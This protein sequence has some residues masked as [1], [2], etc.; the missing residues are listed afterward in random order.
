[1]HRNY[2]PPAAVFCVLGC[3]AELSAKKYRQVLAVL[4]YRR[5]FAAPFEKGLVLSEF[6]F[7]SPPLSCLATTIQKSP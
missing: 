1:M 2:F 4:E 3:Y 7:E 5:I 6:Y